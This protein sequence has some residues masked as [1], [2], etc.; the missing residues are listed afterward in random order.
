M[1]RLTTTQ[2]AA[3]RLA[4]G[5]YRFAQ[6]HLPRQTGVAL[7]AR[8]VRVSHATLAD[9]ADRDELF[10]R[11]GAAFE[12]PDWFGRNLDALADCLSEIDEARCVEITAVDA[13]PQPLRATLHDIVDVLNDHADCGGSIVTVVCTMAD[14]PNTRLLTR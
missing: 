11:L 7:A 14:L 1:T 2:L 9:A 10:A 12:F 8:N 6:V 4:P 13:L 3:G 5:V